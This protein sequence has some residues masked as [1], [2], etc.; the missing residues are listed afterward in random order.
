MVPDNENKPIGIVVTL[1]E[2]HDTVV[3]IEGSLTSEI[4]KLKIRIAAHEVVIGIMTL[5]I[6]FL[7]QKGL[8]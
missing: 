6:V 8:K 5:V 3:R 2:I 4:T 1:K 7:V